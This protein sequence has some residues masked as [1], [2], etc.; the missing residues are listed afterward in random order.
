ML[1]KKLAES[2][3]EVGDGYNAATKLLAKQVIVSTTL[4]YWMYDVHYI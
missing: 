1:R 2:L 3:A 4:T